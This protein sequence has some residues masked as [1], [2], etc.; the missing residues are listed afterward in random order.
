MA[1]HEECGTD[2][3]HYPHRMDVG[4]HETYYVHCNGVP[5][6]EEVNRARRRT[7]LREAKAE[8][9]HAR[10]MAR[11]RRRMEKVSGR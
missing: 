3:P 9:K 5:T 2:S 1:K 4:F 6:Q 7:E 10:K 11:V 8:A